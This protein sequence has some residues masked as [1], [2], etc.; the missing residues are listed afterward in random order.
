M[1][2]TI[3]SDKAIVHLDLHYS[4]HTY[5]AIAAR[6]YRSYQL[7]QCDLDAPSSCVTDLEHSLTITL[8]PVWDC[9]H[10]TEQRT[11]PV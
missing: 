6:C 2:A 7:Q 8:K 4:I 5:P 9:M 10:V 11:G 3:H 1:Q